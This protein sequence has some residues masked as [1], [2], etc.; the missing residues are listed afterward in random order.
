MRPGPCVPPGAHPPGSIPAPG[1]RTRRACADRPRPCTRLVHSSSSRAAPRP[2]PPSPPHTL[3]PTRPPRRAPTTPRRPAAGRGT[4]RDGRRA[5]SRVAAPIH[6]PSRAATP[7]ATGVPPTPVPRC[8]PGGRRSGTGMRA[9]ESVRGRRPPPIDQYLSVAD[10]WS[11]SA[12]V[13]IDRSVSHVV[14]WGAPRRVG[15]DHPRR[16]GC[17]S[18][19]CGRLRGSA[20]RTAASLQPTR[21]PTRPAAPLTRSSHPVRRVRRPRPRCDR[22]AGPGAGVPCCAA[23]QPRSCGRPRVEALVAIA[24]GGRR[25]VGRSV[26]R[27][28][29]F[30][31]PDL[32]KPEGRV[33][34]SPGSP[35]LGG[36]VPRDLRSPEAPSP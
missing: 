36:S 21:S 32:R 17:D 6:T 16:A 3:R 29:E 25:T 33:N 5:S 35:E 28:P 31:G 13:L 1:P 24:P 18:V 8:I 26:A 19:G 23:A 4:P 9:A 34:R 22:T 11:D 27:K 15:E 14:R 2:A 20:G 12:H 30:A 7:P 10:A